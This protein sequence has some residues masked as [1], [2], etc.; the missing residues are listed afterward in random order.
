MD[1]QRRNRITLVLTALYFATVV[2]YSGLVFFEY[3]PLKGFFGF[4]RIPILVLLYF[5][6]SWKRDYLYFSALLFFQAAYLLFGK[7]TET[8]LFYGAAA[9][10]AFRLL[11]VIIM[12]KAIEDK[13]WFET[14]L[15]GLPFLFVHLYFIDLV[16]DVL[17][18]SIY[19]WII[20]GLLTSF[21]GGLSVTNFLFKNDRKSLWL[22]ISS[23]L[24]VVQ[25]GLFFVNRFYLNQQIFLQMVIVFYG[26]SNYTF[27]KFMILKEEEERDPDA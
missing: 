2:I 13:R 9:S 19:L 6:S 25:I 7:N 5:Y 26:I 24:F 3:L 8:Y 12:Y 1:A 20:N 22:F 4:M 27:Y 21:L 17:K 18:D 11:M 10:V 16:G 23:L 15:T 14:V